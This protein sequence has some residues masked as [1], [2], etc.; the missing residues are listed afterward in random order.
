MQNEDVVLKIRLVLPRGRI[1]LE[2]GIK[3]AS[4]ALAIL[5]FIICVLVI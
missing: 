4:R 1:S 5:C 2:G 3:A